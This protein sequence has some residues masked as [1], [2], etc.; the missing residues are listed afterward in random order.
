MFAFKKILKKIGFSFAV[1]AI[2]VCL[3]YIYALW[4]IPGELVLLEGEEYIYRFQNIFPI[5][6]SADKDG[7]I[8]LKSKDE[9]QAG[10]RVYSPILLKSNKRGSLELNIS[11]LE[12]IPLKTIKVDVIPNTKLAVC[13]NTIGI[14]LK[15]DGIL[16]V[17]MMEVETVD[18]KRILPVKD[19]GIKP[20]DFITHVNGVEMDNVNDLIA[21]IEASRGRKINIRYRRAEMFYN[22]TV[23][24]VISIDDKRYHIGLWVRDN[25][26]GIGT[27]TFYE[28]DTLYFGAL[29]HGIT[30]IDTGILMP[31]KSGEI[32]E[33]NILAVK[34]SKNGT[35][36]ELKGIFAENKD[37]LGVVN[38][39]STYGVYGKLN[40][41]IINMMPEKLYPIAIRSQVKEGPATILANIIGKE[42]NE[43]EIEIQK[44]SVGST[45]GSK[46]MIIKITDK[47]LLDITGG[48]VQGMSGSPIIQDGKIVGAVTHVLV[49]DPSRGYGIF[50]ECMVK[51]MQENSA[52]NVGKAG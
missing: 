25:T 32:L 46:G 52:I 22:I 23:Q 30:D 8:Q 26:A 31:A 14:K 15:L 37:R 33:S 1:F 9:G 6:I 40:H 21:E 39:N 19:T 42:I 44:V 24:P 10:F 18:G 36:G 50:I 48:I 45:N 13:G 35:P 2:I 29:G 12:L 3:I 51:K 11:I 17:G 5:K 41:T 43:Y 38:V 16:V 28:P 27:L 47:R 20:G 7:I 49:N 34:K 4:S